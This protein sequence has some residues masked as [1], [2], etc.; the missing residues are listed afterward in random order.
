[1]IDLTADGIESMVDSKSD[2]LDGSTSG[3]N[4]SEDESDAEDIEV[5]QGVQA[6]I[7]TDFKCASFHLM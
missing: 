3:D 4:T 6:E 1:L 2:Y 7:D 5:P